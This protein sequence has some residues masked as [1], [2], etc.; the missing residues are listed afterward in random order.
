[1]ETYTSPIAYEQSFTVLT[2]PMRNGNINQLNNL[3]SAGG[4]LPYLWGMETSV[5]YSRN[6]VAALVLTVPMRN[7]N[8]I[9]RGIIIMD[10][11]FLPYLWGMETAL[12]VC[13]DCTCKSSY[14]TYEE[15]KHNFDVSGYA[16]PDWFLPYLWGMETN[17]IVNAVS[18]VSRFLPYLWGMET[19][20]L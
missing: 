4:F 14:R 11:W 6:V 8:S 9:Q 13:F 12:C 16:F 19:T 15:W 1:M 2:V 18:K 17:H 10:I 3:S 7:G 5:S 20:L